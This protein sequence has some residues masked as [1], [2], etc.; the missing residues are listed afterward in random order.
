MIAGIACSWTTARNV[1][2]LKVSPIRW[3]AAGSVPPSFRWTLVCAPLCSRRL[4]ADSGGAGSAEGCSPLPG[5]ELS[6]EHI[7]YKTQ[8]EI[9]TFQGREI[10]LENLMPILTS[11][12]E[13][14]KRRELGQRLYEVFRTYQQAEKPTS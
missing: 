3:C 12:Q 14:A 13:A 1:S 11:E 7:T 2:V 8:T 5:T 9:V 6:M 10:L 4:L